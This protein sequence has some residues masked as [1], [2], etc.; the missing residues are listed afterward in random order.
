MV[1]MSN[2]KSH[3]T[4]LHTPKMPMNQQLHNENH[5]PYE[6]TNF[7]YYFMKL[8]NKRLSSKIYYPLAKIASCQMMIYY[9]HLENLSNSIGWAESNRSRNFVL[10]FL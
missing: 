1:K 3:K 7:F 2:L 4:L 8:S 5:L 10:A 6:T 9:S